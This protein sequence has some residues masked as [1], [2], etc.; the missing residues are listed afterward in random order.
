MERGGFGDVVGGLRLRV[1]DAVGGDC[2]E[3]VW[4]AGLLLE[5]SRVVR[6]NEK[7]GG[8]EWG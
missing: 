5:F 3:G 1:V 4:L 6:E 2:W 8:R 7:S